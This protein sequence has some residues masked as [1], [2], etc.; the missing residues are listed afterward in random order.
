MSAPP[1]GLPQL[2]GRKF[3]DCIHCGLCTSACPT[4]LE[5]GNEADGPRGRIHLMKAVTDGR[6]T[7]DDDSARHLDLCLDCRACETAC[8]S[9]VQYGRLIEPFRQWMRESRVGAQPPAW[10]RRFVLLGVF[11]S[12]WRTRAALAP[13]KLLRRSGID[14]L[15]DRSGLDR[16][17]PT[18]LRRMRRLL[19]PGGAAPPLPERLPAFGE[20]R[21]SVGLLTGC[22]A[23]AAMRDVHWATARVLQRNGCEV[24]V[25]RDQGCCGAIHFHAGDEEGA[26]ELAANNA[27]AFE[28]GGDTAVVVNVA[29]CGAMMKE[30]DHLPHGGQSP[31]TELA[32]KTRDIHEFLMELGPV[33]PTA[34]VQGRAVYHD[35]CHL[36]HAQGIRT[37]PRQLLEMIPG[38]ELATPDEAEVCCGAAGTYNLTQPEMADRL[39]RR[40]TDHLLATAPDFVVSPNAGCTL[41][42]GAELRD[43]GRPDLWPLHPMQLLDRSYGPP[44]G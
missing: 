22:V 42:L 35:A 44:A 6:V 40:K 12:A 21:A 4:Y 43:R 31:I 18:P 23:D 14:A 2:D 25:P 28:F 38:L 34:P 10:F 26:V 20:Q 36:C 39:G 41:Q 16:L 8:P 33:A 19:P 37:Q 24:F 17:L 11:P 7:L 1:S 29:G 3:L 30:Y 32:R 27:H 13:A 9:G 5:T 15:I